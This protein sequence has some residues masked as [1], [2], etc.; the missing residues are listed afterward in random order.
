MSS[1]PRTKRDIPP[2]LPSKKQR[3]Q[4]LTPLHA[5]NPM[6]ASSLSRVSLAQD[7]Y[8][9]ADGVIQGKH[10]SPNLIKIRQLQTKLYS[11]IYSDGTNAIA[12]NRLT[13]AKRLL[14]MEKCNSA[15]GVIQTV[16]SRSTNGSTH[17]QSSGEIKLATT[18]N[19][20]RLSLMSRSTGGEQLINNRYN[21]QSLPRINSGNGH[22]HR[23]LSRTSSLTRDGSVDGF[24]S[25]RTTDKQFAEEDEATTPTDSPPSP[26]PKPIR[27]MVNLRQFVVK[28]L[29]LEIGPLNRIASYHASGSDSG[30]GSGDSAQS[31]AANDPSMEFV[32]Q[33]RP[34][35]VII[36]NPRFMSSSASQTT[37]K[38]FADFDYHEAEEQL[39]ALNILPLKQ[40]SKYDLENFQTLLL[41][42]IENKPLDNGALNTFRMMLSETGPRVLANHMTRI[43]I[44][45]ILG[46]F[47]EP[48]VDE[49]EYGC[50]NG[51]NGD[52]GDGI[53][54]ALEC[55][56]IE[57][58]TMCHGEQFRKDLIERTECIRL[59]VAVT[60]LTCSNDDERA[61]T[62]NKWIQVAIDTKTALGNLFGFCSIML[63]LCMPQ[64]SLCRILI[65][66]F[67]F[68]KS[69][70]FSIIF[71]NRFK[72]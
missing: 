16:Q 5:G 36:K 50:D 42:A 62:L 46:D 39:L 27:S 10:R 32:Q 24:P 48:F 13:E 7:K 22:Q 34:G 38:S 58:L 52:N 30:N 4:S 63:G 15:D 45:L 53:D 40:C 59:L 43:D 57:L 11:L 6:V 64:V 60:I 35:G 37:L 12:C 67:F 9:S 72:S 25:R 55:T 19:A 65:H 41:P 18:E 47:I 3:S 56:G 2:R 8:C 29:P 21:T 33:H 66:F 28:D 14:S 23:F 71:L 17:L 68:I 1:P 69:I 61:E 26:P 44:K 54:T 49:H 51:H 20:L 70:L 31:S